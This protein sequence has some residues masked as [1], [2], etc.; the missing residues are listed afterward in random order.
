MP[1]FKLQ[2]L[3][4]VLTSYFSLHW[5]HGCHVSLPVSGAARV[6]RFLREV[7]RGMHVKTCHIRIDVYLRYPIVN[8]V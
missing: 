4:N 5:L 3:S 2:N 8:I 1:T 6:G 7:Y